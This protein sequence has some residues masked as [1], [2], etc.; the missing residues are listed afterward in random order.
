MLEAVLDNRAG[1]L[2]DI[3]QM[4]SS[5]SIKTSRK[6]KAGAADI[7]F[8]DDLYARPKGF[9]YDNGNLVRLRKDGVNLFQGYVFRV[10]DDSDREPTLTVYDQ[11]RYLMNS[12]TYMFENATVTDMVRRIA[13]D[14]GLK[15][16][17]LADTKHAIRKY[18]ADGVQEKLM[19][20]IANNLLAT[21]QVT[22]QTFVL[23]DDFGQLMLQPLS[24]MKLPLVIG[25]KSLLYSYSRSRSIDDD[26]YNYIKL[27]RDNK[28][29]GKRDLYVAKDSS[30]IA[31]WGRLQMY[32]KVDDKLNDAQIAETLNTL[33]QL[34][35]RETQTMKLSALGDTRVRAG[36]TIRLQIGEIGLDQ[37]MLV[38]ECVQKYEGDDHTMSLDMKVVT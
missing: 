4:V 19:D 27:V 11:M 3:S 35:N 9:T 28:K 10:G 13:G 32:K 1:T 20:A 14:F 37:D 21:T 34:K 33:I 16:G 31:E 26:T 15:V 8:L 7:T 36:S 22:G 12:E 2:W 24:D 23:Y 5:I 18:L 30:T 6:G 17:T 25:D 38:E 29:T